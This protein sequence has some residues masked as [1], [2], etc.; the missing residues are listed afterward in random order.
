[1]ATFRDDP[2]AYMRAYRARKRG[3][4]SPAPAKAGD[5]V[6]AAKAEL[7]RI[8]AQREYQAPGGRGATPAQVIAAG[9]RAAALVM[10]QSVKPPAPRIGLREMTAAH[11]PAVRSM[12]AVGGTAGKGLVAQGRGMPLPPDQAAVS[13][14]THAKQF[15]ANATAS[16]NLLAREVADLKQRVGELEHERAVKNDPAEAPEPAWQKLLMA[17]AMGVQAY[18]AMCQ[19]AERDRREASKD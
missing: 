15:E 10:G 19:A 5:R 6:L 17:A 1:M 18:A 11:A 14:Y 16:I 8:K 4:P 12:F 9:E 13:T 7:A 3:L 2:A